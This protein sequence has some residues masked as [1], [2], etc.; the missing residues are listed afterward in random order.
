M[1]LNEIKKQ[2]DLFDEVVGTTDSL[3][4]GDTQMQ[5][6]VLHHNPRINN[7]LLANKEKR[8]R[9]KALGLKETH[10]RKPNKIKLQK[11]RSTINT[12]TG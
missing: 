11:E 10:K 12:S 4:I 3:N 2:L 7:M 9:L 8:A 1:D 6:Q 5:Q